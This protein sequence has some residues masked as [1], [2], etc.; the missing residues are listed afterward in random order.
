[1]YL[2]VF[3]SPNTPFDFLYIQAYFYDIVLTK[4][5]LFFFFLH[6]SC[7]KFVWLKFGNHFYIKRDNFL[8]GLGRRANQVC[9]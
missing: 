6:F 3:L 8:M 5:V 1:M 9:V 7:S 2:I 4:V